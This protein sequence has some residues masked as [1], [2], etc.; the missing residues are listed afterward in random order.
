MNPDN[1]ALARTYFIGGAP[2]IGKT[3]FSYKLAEKIGGHV[4]STD[5]IRSAAKKA[6]NDKESDLFILNRTENVSDAEW[7]KE[8][9]E[10]PE[11][12]VEYQ[13]I[14]SKAVWPSILSFCNTFCEDSAV[15]IV[16]G[17]ALLP[18]LVAEMEHKPGHVIYVGNTSET[19]FQSMLEHAQNHPEL[20]WMGAMNYS[21]EKIQGMAKFVQTMSEYFKEESA[22][23]GFS[24]FEISD[25][26]FDSSIQELIDN[27]LRN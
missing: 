6:N 19:H 27:S 11:K 13:N 15:H 24:Y 4:V 14:E 22:K 20:D 5:S 1:N 26:N 23:Y 8:H 3:I 25:S 12:I 10:T 16:E 9:L 21:P 7:L 18:S 2:R 17:V